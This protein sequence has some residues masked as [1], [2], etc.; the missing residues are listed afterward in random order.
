MSTAARR[1]R[2]RSRS[3]TAS[4]RTVETRPPRVPSIH[5][6]RPGKHQTEDGDD[7][8]TT[9]PTPK[10]EWMYRSVLEQFWEIDPACMAYLL[11]FLRLQK[12]EK[13]DPIPTYLETL[14]R[15]LSITSTRSGGRRGPPPPPPPARVSGS[16]A[17]GPLAT[18]SAIRASLPES[19]TAAVCRRAWNSQKRRWGL[20]FLRPSLPTAVVEATPCFRRSWNPSCRRWELVPTRTPMQSLVSVSPPSVGSTARPSR[21]ASPRSHVVSQE[22]R[23]TR[24][25]SAD[26]G[27]PVRPVWTV[28]DSSV[29]VDLPSKRTLEKF[30]LR[31]ELPPF[32][33]RPSIL[34]YWVIVPRATGSGRDRSLDPEPLTGR[35]DQ[36]RRPDMIVTPISIPS[37]LRRMS[38]ADQRRYVD[39]SHC[40]GP[41]SWGIPLC[42]LNYELCMYRTKTFHRLV[43]CRQWLL[44]ELDHLAVQHLSSNAG[45]ASTDVATD[46][47]G[48]TRSAR[49]YETWV[50]AHENSILLKTQSPTL[51]HV[52]GNITTI[53]PMWYDYPVWIRR[54]PPFYASRRSSVGQPH[55]HDVSAD[56]TARPPRE[57]GKLSPISSGT[58]PTLVVDDWTLWPAIRSDL[59]TVRPPVHSTGR[60]WR[61]WFRVIHP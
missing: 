30:V 36:W 27:V 5:R 48:T 61:E 42:K 22:D 56:S 55:S 24:M 23:P 21:D 39:I 26:H 11:D 49:W 37:E 45:V 38:A 18:S 46:G 3:T 10:E 7:A 32:I 33:A 29:S 35:Y 15:E 40:R 25:P 47:G 4:T 57:V 53:E 44:T 51:R 14:A 34:H 60:S 8:P 6:K 12:T 58:S 9:R 43:H 2:T 1:P 19:S 59:T 52:T 13:E 16:S 20:V 54:P 17:G 50:G 31:H 41:T 28:L